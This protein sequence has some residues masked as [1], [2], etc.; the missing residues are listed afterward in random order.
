MSDTNRVSFRAVEEVT[1][2]T[3][4]ASPVL[5]NICH[6]G[7][8]IDPGIQT[9]QSEKICGGT[10]RGI[11]DQPKVGEDPTGSY[12]FE[13]EF[14]GNDLITEGIFQNSWTVRDNH[15][16]TESGDPVDRPAS[17]EITSVA[18]G[19]ITVTNNGTTH[20][21]YALLRLE[22]FS[23][24]ANNKI[25]QVDTGSTT[26]SIALVGTPLTSEST[27]PTT[28]EIHNVGL[29]AAANADI[30]ATTSGGNALTSSTVDFTNHGIA[31]GDWIKVGGNGTANKFATTANNGWVR[32]SAVAANRIDLD[33][34][35]SG[36][37]TDTA[38]GVQVR[39]WLG[40]K[41]TDASTRKYYTLEEAFNDQSPVGYLYGKGMHP[42]TF[43]LSLESRAI[44]TGSIAFTGLSSTSGTTRE[45]GASTVGSPDNDS[46]NATSNVARIAEGGS[47][48]SGSN[49]VTSLSLNVANNL[50]RQNAVGSAA[51]VGIGSGDFAVTGQ[52]TSYFDDMTI[53][54]K[55]IDN[56]ETSIH[57]NFKDSEFHGYLWDMPRV[58][59]S[60]GSPNV[61]GRNQDVT[62]PPNFIA[63][64]DPTLDYTMKHQRFFAVQE[65]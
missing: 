27:P 53:L 4:P 23:T 50:R 13:L 14:L 58:K 17:D 29:Q 55:V 48:I 28:A 43:S 44:A 65:S 37:A 49:F 60:D 32:V 39:L 46:M 56:T 31:A 11:K 12:N 42:D 54:N 26:T 19:A 62:L 2:G 57:T 24:A 22:G 34:V 15:R 7:C 8:S 18:S 20:E 61:P 16:N 59:Y 25:V 51:S 64:Q 6:T 38:T 9:T 40:D 63:L 1:A 21:Q 10:S 33:V 52:I 30:Q 3:T 41:I 35:P 47:V 5:Q 36:W 45:S